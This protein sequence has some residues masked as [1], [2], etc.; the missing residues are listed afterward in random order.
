MPSKEFRKAI[1]AVEEHGVLLVY[2]VQNRPEPRSLWSVLYPRRSMRWAWDEGADDRVAALWHLRAELAVSK[3]V[4][5][6]KW[7]GGR[8]T[9]FSRALFR[10]MLAVFRASGDLRAKLS[11][12]ATTLLEVLSDD[13]PQGTAALRANANLEGAL[14][15]AEYTRAMR[16]LWERLLVVGFGEREE[17]GFPSLAVGA[18]ELLFEDLWDASSSVS[19]EDVSTL[20]RFE[21]ASPP[22]ARAFRRLTKKMTSPVAPREETASRVAEPG[23]TPESNRR[24]VALAAPD[25]VVALGSTIGGNGSP[26]APS[27]GRRRGETSAA[28]R[29]KR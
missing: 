13:S 1:A 25:A 28:A 29:A 14:N 20:A 10:S 15:E 6:S 21:R 24:S 5:Y 12:T 2:P 7:L 17:G 9:F 23:M 19:E 18:T 26:R 3:R 27:R 8:A 11:R 4:V 16:V 22:F